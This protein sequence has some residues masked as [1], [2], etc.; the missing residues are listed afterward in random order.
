M[1][2]VKVLYLGT[3]LFF[4]SLTNPPVHPSIHLP[5]H[6]S[7][8]PSIHPANVHVQGTVST[9][10]WL[11]QRCEEKTQNLLSRKHNSSSH[12]WMWELDYKEGWA[13]KNWCF[14]T[15]VLKKTLE[16]PLDC[17]EIQ[18]VHPKGNQ[19]WKIIGG[20]DIEAET[21]ILWPPDARSTH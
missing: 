17:K 3:L 20:T 7:I 1:L 5:I 21:P 18:L 16:S 12:V 9:D 6:S 11:Y 4:Y 19:S 10:T 13:L 14:W 2:G 8:D 15:V